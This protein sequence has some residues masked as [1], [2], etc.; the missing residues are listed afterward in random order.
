MQNLTN[1]RFIF[2][3]STNVRQTLRTSKCH[4]WV[5][6]RLPVRRDASRAERHLSA[7]L[8]Q[9]VKLAILFINRKFS[10]SSSS[11]TQKTSPIIYSNSKRKDKHVSTTHRYGSSIT[12]CF[13]T[14][15]TALAHVSTA[16]HAESRR[17]PTACRSTGR[18]RL[19]ATRSSPS[20]SLLSALHCRRCAHRRSVHVPSIAQV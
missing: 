16:L 2:S 14:T 13:L 4:R 20:V 6:H 7:L 15:A 10:S 1:H 3:M 19:P 9:L 18:S 17:N 12:L 8:L 11:C 5:F